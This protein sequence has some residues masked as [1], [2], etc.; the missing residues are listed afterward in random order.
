MVRDELLTSQGEL[1]EFT[2]ELRAVK[3][4]LRDKTTLLDGARHE[5][6]EAINS[7]ERLTK[8]CCGLRGDLHQQVTLVAQ[9]DEVIGRLR[10]EACTQWVSRWLAF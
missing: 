9:R 4:E 2:E 7:T 3:D 5:V 1:R 6:S 8:E 10:D